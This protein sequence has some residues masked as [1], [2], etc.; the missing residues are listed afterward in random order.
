MKLFT[1]EIDGSGYPSAWEQDQEFIKITRII[2]KQNRS[3]CFFHLRIEYDMPHYHT[4]PQ[5]KDIV[6]TIGYSQ[7]LDFLLR[8]CVFDA[9]SLLDSYRNLEYWLTH[10][11]PD[12]LNNVTDPQGNSAVRYLVKHKHWNI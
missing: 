11:D 1:I 7:K 9:I 2:Q 6:S 10:P 8:N 12:R 4:P 5:W 3:N